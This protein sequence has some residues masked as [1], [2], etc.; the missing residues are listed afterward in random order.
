MVGKFTYTK[1]ANPALSKEDLKIIRSIAEPKY[2]E[3]TAFDYCV[4]YTDRNWAEETAR[5]LMVRRYTIFTT[6]AGPTEEQRKAR[7]PYRYYIYL[8]PSSAGPAD[9][10]KMSFAEAAALHAGP[11]ALAEF[12]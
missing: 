6:I 2:D 1:L 9:L 8:R 12:M 7:K 10:E 5:G 3:F 11:G 4:S